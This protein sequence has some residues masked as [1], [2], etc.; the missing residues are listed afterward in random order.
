MGWKESEL[1]INGELGAAFKRAGVGAITRAEESMKVYKG[2]LR[3]ARHSGSLRVRTLVQ[4]LDV[5]GIEPQRSFAQAFP[6]EGDPRDWAVEF[7]NDA[8]RLA[9]IHPEGRIFRG[10]QDWKMSPLTAEQT[11][12]VKRLDGLKYDQPQAAGQ[13]AAELCQKA[14]EARQLL[15]ALQAAGVWGSCLVLENYLRKAKAILGIAM[16]LAQQHRLRPIRAGLILRAIHLITLQENFTHALA[17][18]ETAIL[19]YLALTDLVGVGKALALRGNM[20]YYLDQPQEAIGDF[21]AALLL[22]GEQKGEERYVQSALFSLSVMYVKGNQLTKAK[23]QV[24]RVKAYSQSHQLQNAHS[25]ARVEWLQAQIAAAEG[26]YPSAE[27]FYR[28]A[29]ASLASFP[30]SAAL[31]AVELVHLLLYTGQTKEATRVTLGMIGSAFSLEKNKVLARA[32]TALIRAARAGALTLRVVE[33]VVVG[34]IKAKY[35]DTLL[36]LQVKTETNALTSN[37]L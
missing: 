3:K 32:V 17:M 24:E 8:N 25:R 34:E 23:Q 30:V 21:H 4:I 13:Q 18:A 10:I 37:P 15:L 16:E 19:E 28:E 27:S 26:N 12:E 11:A 33:R 20:Y 7:Y 35:P 5:L 1:A 6:S 9:L 2:F 36:W 22:L 14:V 31:A 29:I